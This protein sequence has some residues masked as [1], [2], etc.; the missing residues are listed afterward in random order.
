VCVHVGEFFSCCC[1]NADGYETTAV[2]QSIFVSV[3]II[4]ALHIYS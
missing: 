1:F 3:Y 2:V 4:S